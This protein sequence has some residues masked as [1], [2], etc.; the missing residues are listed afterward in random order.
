MKLLLASSALALAF[1]LAPAYAQ[2]TTAQPNT[3][4]ATT[5]QSQ[6]SADTNAEGAPQRN[7]AEGSLTVQG[8]QPSQ[9]L[10]AVDTEKLVDD[11]AE[12]KAETSATA[13]A[14]PP[15]NADAETET[16]ETEEADPEATATATA[17]A[18]GRATVDS[19]AVETDAAAVGTQTATLS[20]DAPI[21]EEVQAVVEK[22][23]YTTEDIVLAQLEAI[24][25]APVVEP[26][27]VTTTVTTPAPG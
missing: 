21:A 12:A 17:E 4:Q 9:V 27:T 7:S 6:A 16:A 20:P 22:G 8:V 2:V 13:E 19:A 10:G 26:T 23:D 3:D 11:A 25:N 18:E 15:E 5:A 14:Q 24:R 1:A